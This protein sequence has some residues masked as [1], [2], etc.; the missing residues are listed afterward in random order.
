MPGILVP[1]RIFRLEVPPAHRL[2]PSRTRDTLKTPPSVVLPEG[3]PMT[4]RSSLSNF[5]S[6][7]QI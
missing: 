4:W 3:S 2:E 5:C 1:R 7:R 6:R